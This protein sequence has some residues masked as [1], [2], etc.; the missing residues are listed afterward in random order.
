MRLVSFPFHKIV[1]FGTF[2]MGELISKRDTWLTDGGAWEAALLTTPTPT[3]N[4]FSLMD[5]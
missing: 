4:C 2:F 5:K 3:P 1:P